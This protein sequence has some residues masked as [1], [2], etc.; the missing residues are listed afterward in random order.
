LKIILNDNDKRPRTK[1]F[2]SVGGVARKR[3]GGFTINP[4]AISQSSVVNNLKT[5]PNQTKPNQI[6]SNQIKSNQIKPNQTKSNQIK[7]NQIKPNQIKSN[8]IKPNHPA[9]TAAPP[10]RSLRALATNSALALF[11]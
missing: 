4:T 3:R 2:P 10:P 9:A 8:Q 7:S 6:K 5:K 1:K 11:A